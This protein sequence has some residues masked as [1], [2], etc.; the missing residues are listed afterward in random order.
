MTAELSLVARAS[1]ALDRLKR[2][3]ETARLAN[4][5]DRVRTR[6]EELERPA[7]ELEHVALVVDALHGRGIAIELPKSSVF[8]MREQLAALR[9]RYRTDPG[10]ITAADGKLRFSLWDPLRALPVE[11]RGVVL[12]AWRSH[13]RS[14]IREQ[15]VELLDVLE[16]VPGLQADAGAIRQLATE[17]DR[18]SESLP[19]DEAGI[20]HLEGIAKEIERRWQSVEGGGIPRE[21]VDFLAAA[22]VSGAPLDLLTPAVREWLDE[23]S[24]TRYVRLSLSGR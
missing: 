13:A 22:A 11:L 1:A 16:H 21:V 17:F 20:D 10:Q 2:L 5:G 15:S 12:E 18:L 8:S 23:R 6:A 24:L 3:D 9:D 14:L 19:Q 7:S 4:E